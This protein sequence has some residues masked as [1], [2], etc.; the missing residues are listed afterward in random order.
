MYEQSLSPVPDAG[1]AQL[2]DRLA[3]DG[4]EAM[5]DGELVS[6]AAGVPLAAVQPLV[7]RYEPAEIV[8]LD[9]AAFTRIVPGIGPGKAAGLVAAV[10]LARRGLVRFQSAAAI[11]SCPAD[12]LPFLQEIRTENREHFLALYLNARNQLLRSEVVSIGSLSASIVHPREVFVPAITHSAASIILAHNHPSGDA[13]PSKEDVELTRRMVEAGGIM[14]VDI[15]DHIIVSAS[16]FLSLK[17]RG[18][19]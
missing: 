14:G 12:T 8:D 17:E 18:L 9:A 5:R 7:D 15:L 4:A 3:T 19:M 1:A 10:E 11:I 16:E 13:T 2:R 6:L